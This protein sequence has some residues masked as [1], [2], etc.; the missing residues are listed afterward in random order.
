MTTYKSTIEELTLGRKKTNIPKVKL[1]RSSECYEYIMKL[2][3]QDTIELHETF[4]A[5]FIN[6]ANNTIG[7]YVVSQGGITGCIVDVR[8]LFAAALKVGAV[9]M[10]VAHNHPSGNLKPS[11]ADLKIT[12]C[13]Q[14]V[15]DVH[16]MQILDHIIVTSDGYYS[17][18][19]E[20]QL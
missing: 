10:V 17:F 11:V 7:W 4:V 8:M 14:A 19:D 6:Q 1:T 20:G 9:G 18:G 2:W 16:D 15:A 5:V 3:N 12:K 13:I